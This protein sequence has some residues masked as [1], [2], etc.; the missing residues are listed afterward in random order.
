LQSVSLINV[1]TDIGV[2]H[3]WTYNSGIITIIYLFPPF[4]SSHLFLE[5]KGQYGTSCGIKPCGF[6]TLGKDLQEIPDLHIF[7]VNESEN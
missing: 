7:R 4:F 1:K 5:Y 3:Q 2:I 6:A